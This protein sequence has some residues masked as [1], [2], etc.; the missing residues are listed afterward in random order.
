MTANPNLISSSFM[1]CPPIKATPAW[2]MVSMPPFMSW[3]MASPGRVSL[4]KA[5]TLR[6]VRG[7]PPIA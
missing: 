2:A 3:Y 7:T 5:S 6:A 1:L 4:G